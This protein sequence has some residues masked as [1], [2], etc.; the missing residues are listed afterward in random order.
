[1]QCRLQ[2]TEVFMIIE[3]M[4]ATDELV[5]PVVEC[6][7]SIKEED[8]ERIIGKDETTLYRAILKRKR[9]RS[10]WKVANMKCTR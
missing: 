5:C 7:Q 4:H 1:M 9:V 8:M 10:S 6:K 3:N 2:F